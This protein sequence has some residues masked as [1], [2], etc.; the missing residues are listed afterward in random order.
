M[1]RDL[2]I[3]IIEGNTAEGNAAMAAAGLSTN[4]EQYAEAVRLYAPE[5]DIH[6]AFPADTSNAL[7]NGVALGD[8]HGVIIGGSGLRI[9][10]AGN[11]PEVQSQ[12]DLLRAAFDAGLPVLG[13]CWGLQVAAVSAGGDVGPSPRG[14]EV[15]ICRQVTLNAMGKDA[16]MYR[17]KPVHFDSLALHYDEV[18]SL[19]AGA[20]VL[21]SNAHSNIQAATFD[22]GAGVFWGVQYHPEFTLT[23]MAG[24]IR[25]YAT[26][27]VTEGIFKNSSD[28]MR[29]TEAMLHLDGM[30]DPAPAGTSDAA[31]ELGVGSSFFDPRNRC[32]EIDN[33]LHF[34]AS[35]AEG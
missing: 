22:V 25:R 10:G 35:D 33:W 13:S 11:A 18:I 24:L 30:P 12:V 31:R 27:M 4:G 26:D 7:P 34:C 1:H 17:G 28:L 16:L 15:G 20:R 9:R 19:P 14:R 29:S 3:L 5:A 32:L 23:H 2:K 8:F 21:A 6:F